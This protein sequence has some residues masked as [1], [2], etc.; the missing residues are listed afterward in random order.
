MPCKESVY[1]LFQKRTAAAYVLRANARATSSLTPAA[2]AR[3]LAYVWAYVVKA[4]LV[5]SLAFPSQIKSLTAISSNSEECHLSTIRNREEQAH[6]S[7]LIR[8]CIC[9]LHEI[10][11][12]ES[13]YSIVT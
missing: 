3:F 7:S 2:I 5:R 8:R 12:R 13:L 10:T 9:V 11:Y 4:P 1:R 6:V